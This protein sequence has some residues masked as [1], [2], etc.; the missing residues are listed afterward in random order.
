M[1]K[2]W[3]YE[4]LVMFAGPVMG[5]LKIQPCKTIQLIWAAVIIEE[6]LQ[7]WRVKNDETLEIIG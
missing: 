4:W 7:C 2:S 1:A 5:F 6:I 3:L